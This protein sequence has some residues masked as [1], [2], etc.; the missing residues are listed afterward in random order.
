MARM[1]DQ[2][3]AGLA[4]LATPNFEIFSSAFDIAALT[5]DV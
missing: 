3:I 5:G 4:K 2:E 1:T